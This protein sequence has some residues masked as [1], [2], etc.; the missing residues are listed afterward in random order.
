MKVLQGTSKTAFILFFAS[1]VPITLLIDAQGALS[2][3]YPQT[4]RNLIEW[5]CDVFGD[6]LMR[7]PSPSWFQSLI[8]AELFLQVPFFFIAL[9][10]LSKEQ[11]TYPRWFQSLCILY[12]AHVSTTLI[13]IL[14]TFWTST[15]MSGV[16]IV[17]TTVVYMPYLL[18]PLW[19]LY[20]AIVDDFVDLNSN[21]MKSA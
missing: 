15:Q 4:L 18:F 19:L 7:Y 5:Y 11:H 6:V 21:N 8:I 17:M 14:A 2:V 10:V 9:R 13:P 16:Q 1:H 20:L 12:G 3:W